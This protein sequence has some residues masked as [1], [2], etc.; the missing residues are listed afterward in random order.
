MG[1]TRGVNRL[2]VEPVGIRER[3]E[4]LIE[5]E[6]A[7]HRRR[8]ALDEA[9]A[10]LDRIGELAHRAVIEEQVPLA[11][12]AR[13]AGVSRPTLYELVYSVRREHERE[14]RR[15]RGGS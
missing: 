15:K 10:E 14:S 13:V 8:G 6:E 9:Q 1:L 2:T 7:G 4:V 5:L 12:V 11:E 3:A